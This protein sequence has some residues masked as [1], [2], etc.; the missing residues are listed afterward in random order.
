MSG[1]GTLGYVPALAGVEPA[2]PG[3]APGGAVQVSSRGRVSGSTRQVGCSG[4]SS[5]EFGRVSQEGP[6]EPMSFCSSPCP[7]VCVPLS[8][9]PFNSYLGNLK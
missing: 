8:L 7:S 2:V 3:P 4:T 6:E 1:K 5:S 9:L